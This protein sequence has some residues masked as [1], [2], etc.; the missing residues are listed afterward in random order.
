M[1][2]SSTSPFSL[3]HPRGCCQCPSLLCRK[4]GHLRT[5][6]GVRQETSRLSFLSWVRS[7]RLGGP[8]FEPQCPHNKPNMVVCAHNSCAG[9]AET[10]R[11]LEAHWST[12]LGKLVSPRFRDLVSKVRHDGRYPT[13]DFWAL[14]ACVHTWTWIWTYNTHI[15]LSTK[16]L[17]EE[18]FFNALFP[19]PLEA[20]KRPRCQQHYSICK[21]RSP[22]PCNHS[23][24]YIDPHISRALLS[25]GLLIRNSGEDIL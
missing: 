25:S 4:A 8:E 18:V 10:G 14:H 7:K 24:Q 19:W 1:Q 16:R 22:N 6:G 12:R 2:I 20:N 15:P 13:A 23:F 21:N 5:L 11:Y 9:E 3:F 17:Q